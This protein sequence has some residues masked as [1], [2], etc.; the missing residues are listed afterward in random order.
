MIETMGADAW[1]ICPICHNLPEEHRNGIDHLYGKIPQEDYDKLK[2]E[3]EKLRVIETVREDYELYLNED[4]TAHIDFY[5]K[6]QTC[7]AS[8]EFVTNNIKCRV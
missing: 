7:G 4:G 5:A 2:K 1:E 6:C 3:I 8:W